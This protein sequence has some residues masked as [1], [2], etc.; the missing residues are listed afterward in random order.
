[1]DT[2]IRFFK[3]V[4]SDPQVGMRTRMEAAKRLDDLYARHMIAAEKAAMRKER[5]EARSLS[6]QGQGGT[7]PPQESTSDMQ[8]TGEQMDQDRRI[9]FVFDNILHAAEDKESSTR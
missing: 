8:G 6:A 7:L 5:S 1:M 3:Q 2:L 4:M 9:A